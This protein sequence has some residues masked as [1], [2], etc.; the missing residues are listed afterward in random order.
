MKGNTMLPKSTLSYGIGA[1]ATLALLL[2]AQAAHANSPPIRYGYVPLDQVTVPPPY[3]ANNFTPSTILDGGI[4]VGTIFDASFTTEAVA[5]WRNGTIA[6]GQAGTADV[7]SGF[8]LIGGASPSGQAA[9]FVGNSTILIPGLP[10]EASASVV[11]LGLGGLALVQSVD[12][13]FNDTYAYDFLGR[14]TVIPFGLPDPVFGG[15]MDQVGQV[16]VTKEESAT[17]P[18]LRGYRYDPLAKTTTPLFPYAGDPTDQLALVQGINNRGEVLGYSFT[19]FT[20]PAYHERVGFWNLAGVFQPYFYE[21]INTTA[22]FSND[23]DQIVITNSAFSGPGVG[24]SYLV[25]QPGTRLDLA[26][27]VVNVPSGLFLD[28]VVGIDNEGN[29]IGFASDAAY[30]DFFPFLLKPLADGQSNPGEVET[31]GCQLPINI[32]QALMKRFSQHK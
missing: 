4:V 31:H 30:D 16:A 10:G 17:D 14:E 6:I 15:H 27:L 13:S 11:G 21:T 20:N 29:I 32:L 25:P 19:D 9:L 2:A 1:A 18:F 26:S 24:T 28:S 12:A 3:V 5:V 22:L 7:A 8:G 23:L